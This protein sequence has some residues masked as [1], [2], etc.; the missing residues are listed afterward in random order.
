MVK[1]KDATAVLTNVLS[2][3]D[4]K[5]CN[6]LWK[7][8]GTCCDVDKVTTL[9]DS[10]MKNDQKGGYDK[11]MGGLK[12]VGGALDRIQKT[13]T[14]KDDAKTKLTAVYTSNPEYFNGMT[15]DDAVNALGFS[16][17]FKEDVEKFKVDGKTCFDAIKA[18]SGKM[19]CY[20][21]AGTAPTALQTTDG[22][23]GITQASCN[24]ILDKCFTTWRFMF[25]VGGMMQA[26]S[27]LNKA[28]KSDAPA[29]KTKPAPGF[30]GV[31]MTDIVTAFSKCKDAITDAACDDTQKALLCKAN[32]NLREPPKEANDDNRSEDN[33]KGLPKPSRILQVTQS[34][35]AVAVQSNGLDL[36]TSMTTPASSASVDSTTT[37]S[38]VKSA[39]MIVGGI[40]AFLSTIAL[41]N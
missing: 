29:P 17:S 18:S 16:T 19:F 13:V 20:G 12:N 15:V 38:G 27:I 39:K 11:F 3:T 24:A 31:T 8:T 30:G 9:F 10:V 40:I 2:G 37:D 14:N 23:A 5:V 7:T 35:G 32:F 1:S 33:V 28:A 4:F 36:T 25:R 34:S 22:S 41:L 6:E 21:C 26:V